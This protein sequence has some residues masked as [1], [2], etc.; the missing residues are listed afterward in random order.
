MVQS[1]TS[2]FNN[3][4]LIAVTGSFMMPIFVAGFHYVRGTY[5]K[6]VWFMPFPATC[7]LLVNISSIKMIFFQFLFNFR[8]P[9]TQETIIGHAFTHFAEFLGVAALVT[10]LCMIS[11][12]Y[13]GVC[14]YTQSFLLDLMSEIMKIQEKYINGYGERKNTFQIKKCLID[15]IQFHNVIYGYRLFPVFSTT[16]YF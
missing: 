3:S 5:T 10:V 4:M 13:F 8:T 7:V 14:T 2:R 1:F 11:T 16:F 12:T 15:A 9:Y 6:D